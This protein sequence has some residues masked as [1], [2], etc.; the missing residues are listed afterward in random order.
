MSDAN[1]I[2]VEALEDA[3]DAAEGSCARVGVEA[4]LN[5]VRPFPS[6]TREVKSPPLSSNSAGSSPPQ[7]WFSHS[8]LRAQQSLETL[9]ELKPPYSTA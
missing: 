1:L 7:P 2:V 6:F 5:M 3:K 8:R 9:T 4:E